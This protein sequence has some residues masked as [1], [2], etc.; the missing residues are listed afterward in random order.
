MRGVPLKME[1]YNWKNRETILIFDI[2]PLETR[3]PNGIEKI[4]V[5]KKIPKVNLKPWASWIN[6][7]CKACISILRQ[8]NHCFRTFKI[9]QLTIDLMIFHINSIAV[10]KTGGCLSVTESLKYFRYIV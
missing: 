9:L 6:V 2:L 1:M 10:D 3:R 5:K 4:K 7:D 8:F